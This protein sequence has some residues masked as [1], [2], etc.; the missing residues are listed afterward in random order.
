V[1]QGLANDLIVEPLNIEATNAR[2]I[3]SAVQAMGEVAHGRPSDDVQIFR[4]PG[5]AGRRAVSPPPA[6]R[7]SAS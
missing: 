5:G 3:G 1:K 6:T 7:V 2:F 4:R